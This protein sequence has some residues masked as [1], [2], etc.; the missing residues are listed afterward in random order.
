MKI[1]IKYDNHVEIMK[2]LYENS[3]ILQKNNIK[4]DD[5]LKSIQYGRGKLIEIY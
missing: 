5:L 1:K 2:I 3:K 4:F